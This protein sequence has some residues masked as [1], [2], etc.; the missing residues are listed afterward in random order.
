[1]SSSAPRAK[2][3]GIVDKIEVLYA[4]EL[5]DMSATLRLLVERSDS[6]IRKFNKQMG[7]RAVDGYVAPMFRVGGTPLETNTAMIKLYITTDN[8]TGVGDK[9]VYANQLKS[10]IGR[11]L[12]G[13]NKSKDGQGIDAIFGYLSI[14]NRVVL[15]P[16][17]TGS[18]ST[19]LVALGERFVAAYEKG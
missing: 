19:L 4:G 7:R 12:Y 6:D 17:L 13:V 1:L 15:S 5:D 16:E 10:V 11:V 18:T 2:L 8:G 3:T 9:L 14:Q